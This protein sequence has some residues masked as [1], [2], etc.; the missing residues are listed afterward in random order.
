MTRDDTAPDGLRLSGILAALSYAL[1]LT[2]GQAEGHAART[3]LIGMRLATEL[4]LPDADR[5]ALFY[6]LLLKDAGCSGMT[7]P[8]GTGCCPT[9]FAPT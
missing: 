9:T 4:R 2:E 1:D 3:C 7:V 8:S 5:S 6:A